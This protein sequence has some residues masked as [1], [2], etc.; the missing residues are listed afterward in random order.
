M[1][2]RAATVRSIFLEAV[3]HHPPDK[4]PA[5]LDRACAGDPTLRTEVE[6][7]LRAHGEPDALLDRFDRELAQAAD[8][9]AA[10]DGPGTT[11]GP[12]K[13]LEEI[14]EGGRG[15]VWMAEQRQPVQRKVALKIIVDTRIEGARLHNVL[16]G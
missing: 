15:S 4:R 3:E 6:I 12:Y 5:Y 2:I 11:F 16:S 8:G 10:C 7:L 9:A 13:L 14:G 1:G